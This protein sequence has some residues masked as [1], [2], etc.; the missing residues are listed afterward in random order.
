MAS[1]AALSMSGSEVMFSMGIGILGRYM[2]VI[3]TCLLW[4]ATNIAL[5]LADMSNSGSL[6]VRVMVE[7]EGL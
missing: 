7:L 1:G 2:S 6:A 4:I 5:V 3:S